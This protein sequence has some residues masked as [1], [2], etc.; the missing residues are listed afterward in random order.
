LL[1]IATVVALGWRE[2]MQPLQG[3]ITGLLAAVMAAASA[4]TGYFAGDLNAW[5]VLSIT[6]IALTLLLQPLLLAGTRRYRMRWLPEAIQRALARPPLTQA[7][8]LLRAGVWA[9]PFVLLLILDIAIPVVYIL[10]Q[11][12]S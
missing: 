9:L 12:G 3:V 10:P 8:A 5:T 6:L 7:A 11:L 2:V 1:P 4:F